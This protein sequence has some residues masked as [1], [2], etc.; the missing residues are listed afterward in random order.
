MVLHL[1]W[2]PHRPDLLAAG[3]EDNII[4]IWDVEIAARSSPSR[5]IANN[6]LVI[7][8]HPDG[9]TLASRGW[10]RRP[11]LWDIRTGRQVFEPPV[12]LASPAPFRPR[13]PPALPAR[14]VG[15]GRD[16]RGFRSGRVPLAGPGR[17]PA[18]QSSGLA[19]DPGGQYLAAPDSKGITLWS[20]PASRA[21]CGVAG[22]RRRVA[23][24]RFDASGA[25]YTPHPLTMRWPISSGPAGTTIGPPQFLQWY[26]T[27]T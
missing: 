13:G 12:S 6:G 8:F 10:D 2:N 22:E 19:V 3:V 4:R 16:P 27:S 21:H 26:M 7:A 1:A 5:E 14:R 15:S 25:S 17:L 18:A 24:L 11:R 20:L 9:D 23:A